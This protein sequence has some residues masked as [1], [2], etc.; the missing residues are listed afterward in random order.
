M[1]PAHL[2]PGAETATA[3]AAAQATAIVQARYVIAVKNPRD[4]DIVRE[5][6][7]K[8]CRRP[9]FARVARYR[10][11]IGEGIEG[12]SIRFAEAAIRCMGNVVV[13]TQTVF[14]DREK[15]IIQVSVTDLEAN[16][17][18]TSSI[19]VDKTVERRQ[20]KDGDRVISERTNS[21]G[22]KVFLV[23]ATED[24][25][26]NKQNALIS[27][28]I[29]TN[30]LRLIPGDIVEE[31]MA[32]VLITV[33]NSDAKDPDGERLRIYDAFG[34]I[35]VKVGDLKK[36]L[37]H[38]GATLTPKE[39]DELR[40]IHSTIRD[41]ETTWREVMEHKHPEPKKHAGLNAAV[42]GAAAKTEGGK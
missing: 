15:R 32:E 6:I 11:P 9:G 5:R 7:L 28:A 33:Q 12:P 2:S 23:E 40:T 16:V 27:K 34:K 14:D 13:D 22:Q 29:R 20:T 36:F 4:L 41:G 35:G 25:L 30:G 24:Q 1:S 10:K 31:C 18:Y 37:G 8:E 17:P 38:D 3:A 19:T 26:L 39:L 42:D 21:T